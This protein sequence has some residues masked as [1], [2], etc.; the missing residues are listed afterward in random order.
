MLLLAL[1]VGKEEDGALVEGGLVEEG[2]TEWRRE[3]EV[4][5]P[6]E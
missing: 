2:R 6:A 3:A 5:R 1:V 4:A